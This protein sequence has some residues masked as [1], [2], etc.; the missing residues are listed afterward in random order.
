M[1]LTYDFCDCDAATLE[2]DYLFS[3]NGL[4]AYKAGKLIGNQVIAASLKAF[5]FMFTK[6]LYCC[7]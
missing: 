5:I 7:K 4:V 6:H 2:Y 1:K 3:E